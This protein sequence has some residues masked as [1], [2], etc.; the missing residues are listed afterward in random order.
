MVT[1]VLGVAAAVGDSSGTGAGAGTGT[2][3]GGVGDG[4]GGGG[5]GAGGG[6][7]WRMAYVEKW[8][9][10]GCL[11]SCHVHPRCIYT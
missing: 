8:L 9:C 1:P 7:N 4:D 11:V 10:F 2:G 6:L 5:A 3:E